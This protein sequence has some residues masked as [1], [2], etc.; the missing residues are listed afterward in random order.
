MELEI[1]GTTPGSRRQTGNKAWP[2]TA[3]GLI[4][5]KIV[6]KAIEL[7]AL[8]QRGMD[9]NSI[10]HAN[11]LCDALIYDAETVDMLEKAPLVGGYNE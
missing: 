8:I 7:K 11:R 9:V 2:N 6:G 4:S 1:I 3:K 10:E 5:G